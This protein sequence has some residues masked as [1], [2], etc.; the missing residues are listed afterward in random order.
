MV[1]LNPLLKNEQNVQNFMKNY[2]INDTILLK[3]RCSQYSVVSS[4]FDSYQWQLH[5]LKLK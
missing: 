2:T 4:M 1:Y 5:S 3:I